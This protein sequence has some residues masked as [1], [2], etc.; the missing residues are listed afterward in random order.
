MEVQRLCDVLDKRLADHSYLVDDEY[1]LADIMCY[2]WCAWLFTGYVHPESK[3]AAADFLG[4]AGKFP[5]LKNWCDTIAARPAVV[6]GRQVCGWSSP[7]AKPWLHK[8]ESTE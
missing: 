6:R 5:N 7:H 2:P 8:E 4:L 1:S 3:I